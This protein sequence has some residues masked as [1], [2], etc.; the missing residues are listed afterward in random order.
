M[1][2]H[3]DIFNGTSGEKIRTLTVNEPMFAPDELQGL[4]FETPFLFGGSFGRDQK[5]VVSTRNLGYGS[6][7]QSTAVVSLDTGEVTQAGNQLEH[8]LLLDS[9][10]DGFKDLFLV[11]PRSRNRIDL[12]GQL[13]SVK[14]GGSS[15][16]TVLGATFKPTD[17]V[18]GDGVRDIYGLCSSTG[19]WRVLSGVNG[20]PLS[21]LLY[22]SPSPRDQRGSRMPSSA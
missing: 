11:K 9:D 14:S 5:I 21:C 18:D 22:T 17:D 6:Q 7:R 2:V 10:G 15:G 19:H 12:S 4:D 1:L 16:H 3:V 20:D 8:P 13:V